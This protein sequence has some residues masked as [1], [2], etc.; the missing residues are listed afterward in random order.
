[1]TATQSGV[2][3]TRTPNAMSRTNSY[4]DYRADREGTD[5]MS[6]I[7]EVMQQI[8]ADMEELDRSPD[9]LHD[10]EMMHSLRTRND[11]FRQFTA[12]Q[13]ARSMGG[14]RGRKE[15]GSS[16]SSATRKR[17]GHHGGGMDDDDENGDDFI[18]HLPAGM[19]DFSESF[20]GMASG[21]HPEDNMVTSN[22]MESELKESI[23]KNVWANTT[24]NDNPYSLQNYHQN[25]N[26][27][28]HSHGALSVDISPPPEHP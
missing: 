15:R 1:M 25:N 9:T 24:K 8:D 26:S 27:F 4:S 19:V 7:E 5:S 6:Q 28:H 2:S 23:V 14:T 16:E 13:I 20:S 10:D 17:D 18:F 22:R 3:T 12:Q 11:G 21:P